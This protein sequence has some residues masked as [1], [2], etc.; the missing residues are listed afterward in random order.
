MDTVISASFFLGLLLL[1]AYWSDQK[2]KEQIEKNIVF[3]SIEACAQREA[4]EIVARCNKAILLK[5]MN[6]EARQIHIRALEIADAM[7][8]E[9]AK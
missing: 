8:L 1:W 6:E 3:N 5:R 2:D 7:L 9:R 4:E